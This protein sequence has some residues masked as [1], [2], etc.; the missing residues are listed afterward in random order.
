MT[1]SIL[2]T[3]ATGYVGKWF[4]RHCEGLGIT[5]HLL[6]RPGSMTESETVHHYDG[7]ATSLK[8]IF[9][10]HQ[11]E[12]VVHIAAKT[13]VSHTANDV[14][15]LLDANIRF[16]TLLAETMVN[17]GC[18]RLLTIGSYWQNFHT[19]DYRPVNLYAATKQ[20]LIDILQ[21]YCDAS[22]LRVVELKLFDN[23]GPDDDRGKLLSQLME[24]SQNGGEIGV[25]PGEQ[26]LNLLHIKDVAAGIYHALDYIDQ[27][28][29]GVESFYLADD[30]N[31]TLQQV[32]ALIQQHAGQQFTVNFGERSYREREV[33]T[34]PQG[35]RRLPDWHPER[36]LEQG[37]QEL[38]QA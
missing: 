16:G 28:D 34:I 9:S 37:L 13:S 33:M 6:V 15:E 19:L 8:K 29:A 36:T 2:I 31:Y 24:L 18:H 23:Y 17:A 35:I 27:A 30:T 38:L 11:Y 10:Q 7:S 20:A 32:V 25:T 5:P 21:Y 22:G 3:G 12:T 26:E 4:V 1:G 14:D